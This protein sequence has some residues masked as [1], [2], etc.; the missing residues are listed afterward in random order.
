MNHVALNCYGNNVVSKIDWDTAILKL[1]VPNLY[2]IGGF[3]K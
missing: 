1:D 2:E 3:C